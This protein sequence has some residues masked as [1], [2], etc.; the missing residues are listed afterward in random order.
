[1][2][3]APMET[4]AAPDATTAAP[5]AT[6]AAPEATTAAP[7]ATTAAPEATTAAPVETT[8]GPTEAPTTRPEAKGLFVTC[9]A[10]EIQ[11]KLDIKEH[12][13]LQLDTL[14]LK[15][16]NCQVYKNDG[17]FAYFRSPLDGCGTTH[18]TTKTHIKYMNAIRAETTAKTNNAKISRDFQA[19][20]P[21]QCTYERSAILSVVS[22][23]PRKKVVYSS[24]SGLGNFTYE[25]SLLKGDNAESDEI[26]E[27]PHV[28]DLNAFLNIRASIK[29]ND[30]QLSLFI[31]NCWAT[32]TS[33]PKY[34]NQHK[35]ITTGCKKDSTV[36]YDYKTSK[37][38]QFFRMRSFRFLSENSDNI[39]IH[40]EVEACRADDKDS[41][42]AK[43]CQPSSRKR[44]SLYSDA[45]STL[46]TIGSVKVVSDANAAQSTNANASGLTTVS[47]VAGVLAVLVI[48]LVA[49]LVIIH[50]RRQQAVNRP[51]A[52]KRVQGDTEDLLI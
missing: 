52:F 14:T 40:C 24:A 23:S 35:I 10:Q 46:L 22:F 16:T 2:T 7:E 31:D 1:M 28:V 42:C 20:F 27:F 32:P 26:T 34:K 49:A 5:D 21:V 30:S 33:D 38:I 39:H 44:R 18:N 9:T 29:S 45:S 4:T 50:R 17:Q 51:V 47:I 36:Q 48:G 15:D 8:A 37:P 13:G 19:E 12:S 11:I 43:G 41:N 3:A 25:M 6:T